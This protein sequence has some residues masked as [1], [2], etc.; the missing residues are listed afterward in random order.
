MP[1]QDESEFPSEKAQSYEEAKRAL[2]ERDAKKQA[3]SDEDMIITPDD[4]TEE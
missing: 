3:Q 1:A 2:E 4:T